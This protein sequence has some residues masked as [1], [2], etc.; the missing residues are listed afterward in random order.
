[1]NAL[2]PALRSTASADIQAANDCDVIETVLL[3]VEAWIAETRRQIASMW[4]TGPETAAD[5]EWL[6]YLSGKV[7]DAAGPLLALP[8][9]PA[10]AQ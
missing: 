2:T 10:G 6:D 8:S 1:M 5:L 4:S 3:D 7:E 9:A